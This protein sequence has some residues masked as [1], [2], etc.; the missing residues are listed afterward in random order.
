MT[1][2]AL[3]LKG[4]IMEAEHALDERSPLSL[5]DCLIPQIKELRR[6]KL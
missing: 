6:F 1:E 2:A 3:A 5:Y 4:P